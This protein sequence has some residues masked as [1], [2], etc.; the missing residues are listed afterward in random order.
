MRV[1]AGF[2]ADWASDMA[3]E[4]WNRETTCYPK[5]TCFDADPVPQISGCRWR[6]DIDAAAGAMFEISVGLI[7]DRTHLELSLAQRKNGLDQMFRSITEYEGT[8]LEDRRDGPVV[9]TARSSI[10]QLTVRTLALN[11][12]HDSPDA[13][14]T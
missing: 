1:G 12:Y 5:D 13:D 4:G 7:F 14:F 10:D 9:T 8:P 3:Q 6:Y 2:G 11:V